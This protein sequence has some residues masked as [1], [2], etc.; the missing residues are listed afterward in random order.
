[1]IRTQI[2]LTE[3]QYRQLR[4]LAAERNIS[5]AELVRRSV[6]ELLGKE[7]PSRRELYDRAAEWIGRFEDRDG[8]TD[9]S[10]N[11]DRYLDEAFD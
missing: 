11:H 2:Q 8:A 4:R 10:V 5:L 1:M 7:T 3:Q 9:V 6:D